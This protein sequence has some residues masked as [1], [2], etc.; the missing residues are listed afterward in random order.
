MCHFLV[1][2]ILTTILITVMLNCRCADIQIMTVDIV[3][4]LNVYQP[5]FQNLI[6]VA[7]CYASSINRRCVRG[8]MC[9]SQWSH[10]EQLASLTELAC[11]ITAAFIGRY[12]AALCRLYSFSCRRTSRWREMRCPSSELAGGLR[13]NL[14]T[15][16]PC[17]NLIFEQPVSAFS[18][19]GS[20]HSNQ[21]RFFGP[22]FTSLL[23]IFHS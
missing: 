13:D 20:S 21:L 19:R 17:I 1:H 22:Q 8:C 6:S 10:P 4:Q 18:N 2:V 15:R 16:L 5:I 7:L 3:M 23:C 12:A 11:L 14:A 9:S